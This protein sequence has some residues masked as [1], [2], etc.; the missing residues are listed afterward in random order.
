MRELMGK[1]VENMLAN[2][3]KQIKDQLHEAR[4][5]KVIHERTDQ[6]GHQIVYLNYSLQLLEKVAANEL[7]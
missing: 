3:Q 4:D 1:C 7:N 2:S 6:N 5:H